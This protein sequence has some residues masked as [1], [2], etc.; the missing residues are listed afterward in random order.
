MKKLLRNGLTHGLPFLLLLA[1]ALTRLEAQ[2]GP[3]SPTIPAPLVVKDD[4]TGKAVQNA[5]VMGQMVANVAPDNLQL[6]GKFDQDGKLVLAVIPDK[7]YAAEI[8]APGYKTV[9]TTIGEAS[10]QSPTTEGFN[11]V[12]LS[13]PAAIVQAEAQTEPGYDILVGYVLDS[14]HGTGIANATVHLEKS[15]ITTTTDAEGFFSLKFAV[16]LHANP[17]KTPTSEDDFDLET[18]IIN[19]PG[20]KRYERENIELIDNNAEGNSFSLDRGIGEIKEVLPLPGVGTGTGVDADGEAEPDEDAEPRSPS[21]ENWLNKRETDKPSLK[22]QASGTQNPNVEESQGSFISTT[23]SLPDVIYVGSGCKRTAQAAGVKP[24]Y[25]WSC[26]SSAPYPLEEY[27]AKGLS[28]EWRLANSPDSLAAGAVAYRSY[29]VWYKNHPISK[30]LKIDICDSTLCQV[31]RDKLITPKKTQVAASATAGV[32]L[33]ADGVSAIKAEYAAETN[34]LAVPKGGCQ[35]GQTGQ[36]NNLAT[37]KPLSA[38]QAWPCMPD[39]LSK[40]APASPI[41]NKQTGVAKPESDHGRGMS[42]RGS[43]R[44]ATGKNPQGIKVTQTTPWQCILDHYYNDNGN[45]TG[46][47]RGARK[48]YQENGTGD[49]LLSAGSTLFNLDGSVFQSPIAGGMIDGVWSPSQHFMLGIDQSHSNYQLTDIVTGKNILLPSVMNLDSASWSPAGNTL[50]GS[51]GLIVFTGQAGNFDDDYELAT[52][53]ASG[54][55]VTQITNYQSTQDIYSDPSFSPDGKKIAAV[56][57]GETT[58]SSYSLLVTMN[59]D[60]SAITPL[61]LFAD[62]RTECNY[63]AWSPDGQTIVAACYIYGVAATANLYTVAADGSSPPRQ[64]TNLAIPGNDTTPILGPQFTQD[65]RQLVFSVPDPT[66]T[67]VYRSAA[68]GSGPQPAFTIPASTGYSIPQLTRCR[69]FD[70]Y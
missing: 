35:D 1:P 50:D 34:G 25:V 4:F 63:P 65:G 49:G 11:L 44:W 16:S 47:R 58:G 64:V 2:T 32:V 40:G 55:G 41:T 13:K 56:L 21:L 24:H 43:E 60:G 67:T 23:V 20:Y 54:Q 57:E 6:L 19:A 52:M 38:N 30:D 70:T 15:D 18:L 53:T 46:S 48:A 29:A 61:P 17:S 10:G 14:A 37:G 7:T 36:M 31:F 33:S 8:S 3:V 12:P 59:A 45:S 26:A 9:R 68:D 27:V 62:N 42:Q 22:T 69:R 66:G 39:S 51:T 5:I 28:D